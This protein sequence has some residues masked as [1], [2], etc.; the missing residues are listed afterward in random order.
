MAGAVKH[1]AG[2]RRWAGTA[3]APS[4]GRAPRRPPRSPAASAPAPPCSSG[5]CRPSRPSPARTGQN[6]G[7]SSALASTASR[8]TVSVTCRF[9]EGAHR[10][11]QVEVLLGEPRVPSGGSSCSDPFDDRGGRVRA[12]GAHGDRA[13]SRRRVR[14]S[15]CSGLGD[16][17]GAGRADGVAEGDRA[18]VDVDLVHVGV[19]HLRPES[20]TEAKASLISTRSMSPSFMP[21]RS[22][23]CA[24]GVDGAVEVEV[25]LGADHAGGHDPGA[26]RRPSA[27]AR[28]RLISSTAAAPS[29]I[30]EELP[31][32]WMP[33]GM[34]GLSPASASAAG[35]AQALVAGDVDG[36]AGGAVRSRRARDR[37]DLAVE[38]ALGPGARRPSAGSAR[39]SASTVSRVMPR[40]WSRCARRR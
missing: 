37:H 40:R 9:D 4:R 14:S 7:S 12:A 33:S 8:T 15:S 24:V 31:A 10:V 19:V 26:G 21:A 38:A 20:T 36:L 35:V 17:A 2:Q 27:S 1:G 30:C 6:G 3:R 16:Q 28:S 5:R 11:A 34:T 23:T 29:L 39:P 25:G 22:S 13:R 18:A 32:V